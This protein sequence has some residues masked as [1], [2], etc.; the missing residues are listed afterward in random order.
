MNKEDASYDE[1]ELRKY[2]TELCIR[3]D[4]HSGISLSMQYIDSLTAREQSKQ[5][6]NKEKA[7]NCDS[8]GVGIR[9]ANLFYRIKMQTTFTDSILFI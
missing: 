6:Q 5:R 9:Y 8:Q 4:L 3:S 1:F 7:K 2:C